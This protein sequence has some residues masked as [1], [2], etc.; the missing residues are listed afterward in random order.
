MATYNKIVL[1]GNVAAEPRSSVNGKATDIYLAVNGMKKDDPTLFI[2]VRTFNQTAHFIQQYVQKGSNVLVDGKLVLDTFT[3][4]SGKEQKRYCVNAVSVQ[5][6]GGGK[7][8]QQ[9]QNSF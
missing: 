8:Q 6:I 1:M 3:D 2:N 9:P 5:L 7:Q 4:K